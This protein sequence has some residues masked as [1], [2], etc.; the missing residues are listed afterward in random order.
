MKNSILA[1]ILIFS[2]SSIADTLTSVDTNLLE[3]EKRVIDIY[4]NNVS[5]VVN[6]AN[7]KVADSFFYGKVDVPQGSGTGFIWDTDGHIITNYHVVQG[8]NSFIVTF[9]ND[10]KQ[11][12]AIVVGTAPKKDIAVIK[13]IK[14]PKS[15]K[16]ISVGSSE[17]LMVGQLALAIGNPFGFDHSISRGIISALGRKMDGIGGVKIHDMI[18][19]D[20][21]INQGNSGGP[22][23]NSSGD[24]IGMNTMIVSSSHSSAGLG[25][26]VPVDSIKRIAPQLI[27]FGK[28]IR[29]G[30]GVG[31]L[32]TQ[33]RQRYLG[34][35][36]AAL[37]FVDP[38]GPAGLAGLKGMLRDRYGR[39]YLG[40]VIIQIDGK[41]VNTRDDVYQALEKYK[42][43]DTMKIKYIRDGKTQTTQIKLK[44]I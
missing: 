28:V 40:D 17:S 4:K 31:I 44:A 12:K 38:N 27:K 24:L 22:L 30:L 10:K 18:Q 33:V 19:T 9:H 43:G 3:M 5:S 11:Y 32:D 8:G 7:I 13:L 1:L 21:A 34:E 35:K 39:I 16:A 15:L 37:S 42:V 6:V 14:P 26:A 36:G 41:E 20:A 23:L 29:P 2:F 25:F